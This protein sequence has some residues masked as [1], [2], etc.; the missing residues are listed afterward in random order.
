[1]TGFYRLPELG[2]VGCNPL[3]EVKRQLC[4]RLDPY[5][6]WWS[7]TIFILLLFQYWIPL[8]YTYIMYLSL[9]FLTPWGSLLLT[10]SLLPSPHKADSPLPL[11]PPPTL[12]L[13]VNS[14]TKG[15]TW[16]VEFNPFTTHT[17][18][19]SLLLDIFLTCSSLQLDSSLSI[20]FALLYHH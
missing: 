19:H 15:L 10:T 20:L 9:Q 16:N 11:L 17:H 14:V 1:M 12:S 2:L 4:S 13:K 8:P 7:T 6:S 18:T 5:L 3:H